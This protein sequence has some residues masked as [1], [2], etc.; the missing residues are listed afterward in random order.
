MAAL[1]TRFF[2]NQFPPS[3]NNL[4]LASPHNGSSPTLEKREPSTGE[5][6]EHLQP[7]PYHTDCR[8][9]GPS[10]DGEESTNPNSYEVNPSQVA[11]LT[12]IVVHTLFQG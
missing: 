7:P 2:S 9:N 5:E 1:E 11:V 3:L 8:D 12:Q 4:L 10:N 6:E